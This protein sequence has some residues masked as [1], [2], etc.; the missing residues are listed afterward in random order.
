M[1]PF[2]KFSAIWIAIASV[3]LGAVLFPNVFFVL[4][5]VITVLIVITIM[6]L[7]LYSIFFE[8]TLPGSM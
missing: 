5:V 7:V 3:I 1:S 8:D 6:S 2:M 4:S